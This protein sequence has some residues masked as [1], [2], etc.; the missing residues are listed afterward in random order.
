M[1]DI[2]RTLGI[3]KYKIDVKTRAEHRPLVP[4]GLG[5]S[6]GVIRKVIAVVGAPPLAQNFSKRW[7]A[8]TPRT[9]M[10]KMN[11]I[12]LKNDHH[13]FRKAFERISKRFRTI[14]RK[15]IRAEDFQL[16]NQTAM[17]K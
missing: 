16:T 9:K 5:P 10:N 14:V 11:E 1:F 3:E 17:K 12:R 2:L 15:L 8:L 4:R 13:Q 6:E 7:Q